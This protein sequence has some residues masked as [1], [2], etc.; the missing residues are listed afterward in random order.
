MATNMAAVEPID[1]LKECLRVSIELLLDRLNDRL[2]EDM[3]GVDHTFAFSWTEFRTLVIADIVRSAQ[4]S[5][6]SLAE[7]KERNPLV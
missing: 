1:E 5:L 7:G 2:H 3:D 4:V 6:R